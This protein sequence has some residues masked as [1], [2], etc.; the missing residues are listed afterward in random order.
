M[1]KDAY[2]QIKYQMNWWYE[3]KGYILTAL[4]QLVRIRSIYCHKC[5]LMH[6]QNCNRIQS[7]FDEVDI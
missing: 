5:G 6:P 1:R 2:D 7:S 4:S 3:Q